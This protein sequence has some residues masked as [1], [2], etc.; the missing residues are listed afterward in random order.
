MR[1]SGVHPFQIKFCGFRRAEDIDAAIFAGADAVG[2]NF[3]ST[4]QRAVTIEQA[5]KLA[6][7]VHGRACLVGVFVNPTLQ[8]LREVSEV[9]LLDLIQLHGDE[10][11]HFVSGKNLPP[12]IKAIPWRF[13]NRDDARLASEWANSAN[14]TNIAGF[15]VD[16]Y[17]PVQRGGTGRVTRWDILNPLPPEFG[18]QPL[19]L[20][21]GLTSDNVAQAIE[22]SGANAV[23]TASGV[24]SAPGVKDAEK[25]KQFVIQAKKGFEHAK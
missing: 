10:S 15:L 25:M 17:D 14:D 6:K 19:I 11:P 12:V 3:C 22:I 8:V 9:C 5:A 2:L 18:G 1:L 16:A 21:G 13:G 24:E 23:D 4:S 20:A 7:M